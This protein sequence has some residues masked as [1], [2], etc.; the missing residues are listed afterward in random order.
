M[1]GVLPQPC[2][3]DLTAIFIFTSETVHLK[4]G[5]ELKRRG[6]DAYQKA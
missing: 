4:V 2:A 5:K 6:S 3:N 1:A